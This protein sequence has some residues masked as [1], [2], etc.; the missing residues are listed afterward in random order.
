MPGLLRGC[1]LAV[2]L[3]AATL[4]ITACSGD[5]GDSAIPFVFTPVPYTVV[6]GLIGPSDTIM[7]GDRYADLVAVTLEPKKVEA[8]TKA[9]ARYG[10]TVEEA[11]VCTLP[12]ELRSHCPPWTSMYVRVP[13]GAAA[14]AV[15]I[16]KEQPGVIEAYLTG[17][18]HLEGGEQ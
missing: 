10:F 2:A 7:S 5:S 8:F 13:P 1:A 18:A 15:P 3:A 9:V 17:F 11:Y 4:I 12:P 14:D 6:P 16:I